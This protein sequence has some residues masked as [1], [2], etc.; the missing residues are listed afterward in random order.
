MMRLM[1]YA[2]VLSACAASAAAFGQADTERPALELK[3]ALRADP[4][5]VEVIGSLEPG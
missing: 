3:P 4:A 2:V 5:V 1:R